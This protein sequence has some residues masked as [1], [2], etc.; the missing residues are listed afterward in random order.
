MLPS[1]KSKLSATEIADSILSNPWTSAF[2]EPSNDGASTYFDEL[3]VKQHNPGRVPTQ[4]D[5][6]GDLALEDLEVCYSKN[7][8]YP[9]AH[10]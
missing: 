5:R 4:N 2:L 8:G 1:W 9:V 3:T 7:V 6:I 10:V